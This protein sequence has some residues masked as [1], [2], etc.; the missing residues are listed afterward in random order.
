M[1]YIEYIDRDRFMDP[2]IFRRLG[3]Q[4][5]WADADAQ[6]DDELVAQLGRTLRLGPH[7]CYMAIWRCRGLDKLDEWEAHFTSDAAWRDTAALA[8]HRAIHLCDA[9]CYDEL[10]TGPA[11]RDGLQLVE[12]FKA[13]K[14][15]PHDVMKMAYRERA[16][17]HPEGTLNLLI[18]RIGLM[19]PEPGG[20][21]IWT[22]PDYASIDGILR[23][24]AT[25]PE[26][27][28]RNV[29]VYST[30]GAPGATR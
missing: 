5:W 13:A 20:M 8:S 4:S 16:G 1:I 21:A 17:K 25:D 18:H 14:G 30:W 27:A 23:D 19:G 24:L 15:L 28:F 10:I 6:G 22:F 2:H 12:Y 9:G 3:D 26:I 7:P 11:I 29:G